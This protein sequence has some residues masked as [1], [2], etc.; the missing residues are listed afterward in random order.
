MSMQNNESVCKSENVLLFGSVSN[1]GLRSSSP[2]VIEQPLPF[3]GS[4]L[5]HM[6]PEYALSSMAQKSSFRQNISV[7]LAAAAAVFACNLIVLQGDGEDRR[8]NIDDDVPW[9]LLLVVPSI[10]LIGE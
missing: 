3:F 5:V 9:Y 7:L 6:A 4:R 1:C 8:Q 10:F 2:I